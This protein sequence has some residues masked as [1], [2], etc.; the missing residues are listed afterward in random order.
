MSMNKQIIAQ[1]RFC[2]L[3]HRHSFSFNLAWIWGQIK[4]ICP[5]A[6]LGIKTASLTD[7]I[8]QNRRLLQRIWAAGITDCPVLIKI[9]LHVLSEKSQ[10]STSLIWMKICSHSHF[11][12]RKPNNQ[13]CSTGSLEFLFLSHLPQIQWLCTLSYTITSLRA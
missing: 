13:P 3:V 7:M 6:L 4:L 5:S 9:F 10:L 1:L 2:N 8:Q 11:D 12:W